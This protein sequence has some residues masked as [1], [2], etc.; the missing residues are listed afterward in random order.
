MVHIDIRGPS[1]NAFALMGL[2]KDFAR[3]TGRSSHDVQAMLNEMMSGDY[4]HLLDV[5]EEE[6]KYVAVLEGRDDDYDSL[7][8]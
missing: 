3:Q 4:E 8:S 1:G 7:F 5:F 6:F 2:T